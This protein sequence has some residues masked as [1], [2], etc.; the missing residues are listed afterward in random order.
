MSAGAPSHARVVK[1]TFSK[2]HKRD[3]VLPA[4]SV[5]GSDST[6]NGFSS[7]QQQSD[8]SSLVRNSPNIPQRYLLFP[9]ANGKERLPYPESWANMHKSVRKDLSC[10]RRILPTDGLMFVPLLSGFDVSFHTHACM[11]TAR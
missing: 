1:H 4:T 11:A 9:E 10:E 2:K 7:S 8:R 5:S 6:W 3:V